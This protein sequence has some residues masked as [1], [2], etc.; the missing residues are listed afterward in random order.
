MKTIHL[1]SEIFILSRVKWGKIHMD[2]IWER[3]NSVIHGNKFLSNMCDSNRVTPIL[4]CNIT[5][6]I[7]FFYLTVLLLSYFRITLWLSISVSQSCC[8]IWGTTVV[9][10]STDNWPGPKWTFW[11]DRNKTEWSG[12]NPQDLFTIFLVKELCVLKCSSLW[13]V[14]LVLC[15]AC[16]SCMVQF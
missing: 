13:V 14:Y 5:S 6:L 8:P 12:R 15:F 11:E 10:N 3:S 2:Y 16:S 4:I 1:K 9:I 7:F